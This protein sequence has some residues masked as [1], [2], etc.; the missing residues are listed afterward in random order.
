MAPLQQMGRCCRLAAVAALLL[1]CAAA[2]TAAVAVDAASAAGAAAVGVTIASLRGTRLN[3]EGLPLLTPTND[4]R[5][6]RAV[7]WELPAGRPGRLTGVL[8]LFHGERWA[9][10]ALG[11][12]A[13]AAARPGITAPLCSPLLTAGCNHDA[14]DFWPRSDACPECDGALGASRGANAAECRAAVPVPSGQA[15]PRYLLSTSPTRR[16]ARGGGAHQAG[17]GSRL[18]SG[19]D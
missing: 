11:G 16:S 13:A 9:A 3:A 4:T 2:P 19:G 17:A 15:A 5:L 12:R 7:Y 18:R 8:A 10:A 14:S 6:G 1:A